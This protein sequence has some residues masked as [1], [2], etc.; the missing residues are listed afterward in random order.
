MPDISKCTG[1]NCPMKNKC[2]RYTSVDSYYQSYFTTPPIKED[3]ECEYYWED[4]QL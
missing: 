1:V 4:K 2:Y 3:G